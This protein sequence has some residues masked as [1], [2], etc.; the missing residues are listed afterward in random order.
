MDGADA[1]VQHLSEDM[2]GA[3]QMLALFFRHPDRKFGLRCVHVR[4]DASL[5]DFWN[6]FVSPCLGV[7]QHVNAFRFVCSGLPQKEATRHLRIDNRTFADMRVPSLATIE[8]I[9]RFGPLVCTRPPLMTA[10][11]EAVLLSADIV[12]HIFAALGSIRTM[13]QAARVCTLWAQAASPAINARWRHERLGMLYVA[14]GHSTSGEVHSTIEVRHPSPNAREFAELPM[15]SGPDDFFGLVS[16]GDYLYLLGGSRNRFRVFRYCPRWRE[17]DELSSMPQDRSGFGAAVLRGQI[18]AVGGST[19]LS[20][21]AL[22]SVE[23]YDPEHDTWHAVAP[24]RE[25]RHLLGVAALGDRLYAA[26]GC[27]TAHVEDSFSMSSVEVYD[28]DTDTWT[29]V[30]SMSV[31]R[32]FVSAVAHSGMLYVL[33][34]YNDEDGDLASVERYDPST[35]S[36]AP[37]PSMHQARAN[38]AAISTTLGI[39]SIDGHNFEHLIV[40]GGEAGPGNAFASI[41]VLPHYPE[42]NGPWLRGFPCFDEMVY[43]RASLGVALL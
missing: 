16:L 32:S 23:R 33:G 39:H 22:R 4:A 13:A 36:W 2:R 26:G 15:P 6:E 31:P 30:R 11:A 3:S 29:D 5:L 42:G 43:D 19:Q 14:G 24:M 9:G 1:M 20:D 10:T 18:Y 37:A 35:D 27:P 38:A 17:W 7:H 12:P 21:M 25:R 28:V 40:F 8:V 41:E 34:G